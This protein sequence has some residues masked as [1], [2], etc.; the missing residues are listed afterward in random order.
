MERGATNNYTSKIVF[1]SAEFGLLRLKDKNLDIMA[2]SSVGF[3][4]GRHS[5]S[6]SRGALQSLTPV[7]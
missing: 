5:V 7:I 4:N 2:P 6:S 1:K 3:C